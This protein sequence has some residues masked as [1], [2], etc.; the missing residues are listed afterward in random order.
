[1]A[2]LLCEP[3]RSFKVNYSCRPLTDLAIT[4]INACELSVRPTKQP[5]QL[6]WPRTPAGLDPSLGVRQRRSTVPNLA[7]FVSRRTSTTQSCTLS[8][9]AQIRASGKLISLELVRRALPR[10]RTPTGCR[11]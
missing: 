1:M 8:H 5:F 11:Q 7:L 10:V 2:C 6:H 4:V 3:F 9:G